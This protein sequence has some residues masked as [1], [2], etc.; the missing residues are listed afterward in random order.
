MIL[1]GLLIVAVLAC[2]VFV[3]LPDWLWHPL[4]YCTGSKIAVRD[5]K[6]YGIW[7]GIGSDVGEITLVAGLIGMWHHVNCHAPGCPWFGRHKTAD[8]TP[9]CRRHHPDLMGKKRTLVEIHRDHRAAQ[10]GGS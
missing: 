9:L 3:V 6:G 5:C 10:N 2:L 8:G 4:G 7:S 1:V